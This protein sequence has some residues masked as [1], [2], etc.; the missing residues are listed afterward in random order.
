MEPPIIQTADAC[1]VAGYYQVFG[2]IAMQT[3][4]RRIGVSALFGSWIS[5]VPTA[6]AFCFIGTGIGSVRSHKRVQ[7]MSATADNGEMRV[8]RLLALHGSE[9]NAKQFP[10][11]FDALKSTLASTLSVQLEITCVE[12]PFPKGEGYSWWTMPP[13]VRSFEADEFGGF[14]LA[15][16]RVLEAWN[17][18]PPYDLCLGHSQGA[19]MLASLMV[20]NKAPYHPGMGYVFN[21]VAFPNPFRQEMRDM[22]RIVSSSSIIPR[23]LFVMGTNDKITPNETG[24]ELRDKFREAGVMVE[25]IKHHG[26]HAIPNDQDEVILAIAKW[27]TKNDGS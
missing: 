12:G 7:N 24:E 8:V 15:A 22:K 25:T 18:D 2:R 11:R 17:E 13:G 5:L 23:V 4:L 10:S 20:L 27:I 1:I 21:G 16:S 6:S 19:I 9:G 26:G 14:D 3:N